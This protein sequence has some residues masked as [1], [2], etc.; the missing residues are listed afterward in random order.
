MDEEDG[1]EGAAEEGGDQEG[2]PKK[3][4]NKKKDIVSAVPESSSVDISSL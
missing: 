1:D 3:S 2:A 4:K